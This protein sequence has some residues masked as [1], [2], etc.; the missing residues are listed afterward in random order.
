MQLIAAIPNLSAVFY[1][2]IF[3]SRPKLSHPN[4]PRHG[5]SF[6]LIKAMMEVSVNLKSSGLKMDWQNAATNKSTITFM[7]A[8]AV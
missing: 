7:S 3:N 8:K 6:R 5:G 2:A 1:V 4:I